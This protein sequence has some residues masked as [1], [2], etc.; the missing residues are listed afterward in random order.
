MIREPEENLSGMEKEEIE[1]MRKRA[2]KII[3]DRGAQYLLAKY[4][5]FPFATGLTAPQVEN[6]WVLVNA[7]MPNVGRLR[8][9]LENEPVI[10]KNLKRGD[11]VEKPITEVIDI[12]VPAKKEGALR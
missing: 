4:A 9:R 7:V 2:Q 1:A 10:I 3:E 8:G 11:K 5:K 6:M 12:H